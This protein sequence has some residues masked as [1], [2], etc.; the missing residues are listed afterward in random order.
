MRISLE[1]LP[2]QTSKTTF[3]QC[4]KHRASQQSFDTAVQLST[5]LCSEEG[6]KTHK[7]PRGYAGTNFEFI[8]TF[9]T[10]DGC[11]QIFPNAQT[12]NA[13]STIGCRGSAVDV[14]SARESM[15]SIALPVFD[16]LRSLAGRQLS[17]ESSS[18]PTLTG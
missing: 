3:S 4:K 13:R 11:F 10:T 17:K 15:P 16:G 5:S 7:M 14:R 8:N 12:R 18:F 1:V 2:Q 9:R 6:T